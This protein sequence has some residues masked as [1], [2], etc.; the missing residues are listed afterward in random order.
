E[1]DE[2]EY[3]INQQTATSISNDVNYQET[4]GFISEETLAFV[5]KESCNTVSKEICN[6]SEIMQ[7]EIDKRLKFA[8]HLQEEFNARNFQH[9]NI[10][11]NKSQKSAVMIDDIDKVQE[12]C[13]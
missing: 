7:Q 8:M 10:L 4:L 6:T 13:L 9:I 3:R 2:L 12:K 1:L 5:S 11:L